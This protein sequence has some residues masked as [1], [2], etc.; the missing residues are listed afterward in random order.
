MSKHISLVQTYRFW[1]VLLTICAFYFFFVYYL[2]QD[3]HQPQRRRS[4]LQIVTLNEVRDD[5]FYRH[6]YGKERTWCFDYDDTL[7]FSSGAFDYWRR[8]QQENS[9]GDMWDFVNGAGLSNEYTVPKNNTMNLL[10]F[11]LNLNSVRVVVITNRCS[12]V[13]DKLYDDTKAVANSLLRALGFYANRRVYGIFPLH[14]HDALVRIVH[15]DRNLN[16]LIVSFACEKLGRKDKRET[17][18]MYN[19]DRM[20]GDSD[21]DIRACLLGNERCVPFRVLRSTFSSYKGPYHVNLYGE[22]VLANSID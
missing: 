9:S 14:G 16:D 19:C 1:F 17:I 5:V 8:Q 6:K 11:M 10:R 15:S 3:D 2:Y 4:Q 21:E 20:F 12:S 13:T 22:A 18:K 7:M